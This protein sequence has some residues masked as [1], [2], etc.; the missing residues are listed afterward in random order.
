MPSSSSSLTSAN[1][2]EWVLCA[3][4]FSTF[5]SGIEVTLD[6]IASLISRSTSLRGTL[7]EGSDRVADFTVD[8]GDVCGFGVLQRRSLDLLRAFKQL[9]ANALAGLHNRGARRGRRP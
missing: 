6:L 2:A 1:T 8:E 4:R 7:R 5:G 3:K 9:L